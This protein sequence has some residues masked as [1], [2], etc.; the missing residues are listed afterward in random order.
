[1]PDPRFFDSMPPIAAAEAASL[2]GARLDGGDG[3]ARIARAASIDEGALADAVVFVADKKALDQLAGKIFGLCLTRPEFA[4]ALKPGGTLAMV[5]DPRG[6]FA[7]VA[8]KLHR[9]RI[10][11]RAPHPSADETAWV[12]ASAEIGEGAR[13]GPYAVI[14]PGVVIGQGVEIGAHASLYCSIV[15]ARARIAA[16][17]R[18][19]GPGFGFAQGE[20]GLVRTPQL[21]RVLIGDDAEIGANVCIDRGALGDTIIGAGAKIDNLVQIGHNVQ[22]GDQAVLIAQVGI[23]GSSSVGAGAMLAGQVGVADHVAIGAGAR[24]GAQAGLMRDVPPGETWGGYP[25]RPMRLWMKE[26]A[27]LAR[28][29]AG[30][31]NGKGQ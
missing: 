7:K 13:I 10:D 26:I 28:M 5:A 27:V 29:V 19:G 9:E 21:G 30:G 1:M 16:G 24:I 11:K 25:A 17:A 20:G 3:A 2:V 4:D 31:K 14:G 18:I 15:G 12:A 8:E 22:I 23:A 6:A